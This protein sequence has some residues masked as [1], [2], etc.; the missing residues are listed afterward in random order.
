MQTNETG[1][2]V[3]NINVY[4]QHSQLFSDNILVEKKTF[5]QMGFGHQYMLKEM[6]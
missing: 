5:Q 4:N 3:Q 1:I 6:K 2:T